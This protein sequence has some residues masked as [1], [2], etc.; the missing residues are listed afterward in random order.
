[1]KIGYMKLRAHV[2]MIGESLLNIVYPNICQICNGE[3]NSNEKHVCLNCSFELPYLNQLESNQ[4]SLEHLFWGRVDVEA[5][6]SLFNYQKGNQIQGVLHQLKYNGKMKIGTYFG[7]MLGKNIAKTTEF[8][9]TAS[10]HRAG[11]GK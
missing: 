6:F 3:L 10:K 4:L 7:E 1:M 9:I 5:V 2:K 8:H 11:E